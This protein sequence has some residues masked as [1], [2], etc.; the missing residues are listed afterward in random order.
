MMIECTPPA[1]A[2]LYVCRLECYLEWSGLDKRGSYI[3]IAGDAALQAWWY[4]E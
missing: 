1:S 2:V 3:N 4:C